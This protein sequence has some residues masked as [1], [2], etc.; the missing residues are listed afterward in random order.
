ML[1]VLESTTAL[2]KPVPTGDPFY[3][4]ELATNSKR[5]V[6]RGHATKL[7]SVLIWA[8]DLPGPR[9]TG[10]RRMFSDGKTDRPTDDKYAARYELEA[11]AGNIQTEI[12]YVAFDSYNWVVRRNLQEP[13]TITDSFTITEGVIFNCA[14]LDR[15][16]V[17]V[18]AKITVD[19]LY[20][21][22]TREIV[23]IADGTY[24]IVELPFPA[25]I[26]SG[27]SFR[28][29]VPEFLTYNGICSIG[30]SDDD[31]NVTDVG[32]YA[33]ITLGCQR[34]TPQL[35]PIN[36]TITIYQV[37]PRLLS[38]MGPTITDDEMHVCHEVIPGT[39]AF[40]S[41]QGL[42]TGEGTGVIRQVTME[43]FE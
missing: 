24:V 14:S 21:P 4:G 27:S 36:S 33:L 2:T 5:A 10:R 38:Y 37:T 34:Y 25:S 39:M 8:L 31:F 7:A 1:N 19:T 11:A 16:I 13:I 35:M 23:A 26:T 29:D 22:V 43:D 17:S 9:Y 32:G 15:K 40:C 18:G 3:P 12:P 28:V 6:I 30:G 41:A 42:A 20:G